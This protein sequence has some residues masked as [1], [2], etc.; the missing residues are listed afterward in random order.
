MVRSLRRGPPSRRQARR[1]VRGRRSFAD[2]SR[3]NACAWGEGEAAR[4]LGESLGGKATRAVFLGVGRWRSGRTVGSRPVQGVG[5]RSSGPGLDSLG[6]AGTSPVAIERAVK[7]AKCE[8][9]EISVGV[10]RR[11][12]RRQGKV[13]AYSARRPGHRST[14]ANVPVGRGLSPGRL[15]EKAK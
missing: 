11:K 14:D 12:A 9:R 8:R 15:G 13:R 10:L 2:G 1:E 7:T 3:A 6:P 4:L 5:R